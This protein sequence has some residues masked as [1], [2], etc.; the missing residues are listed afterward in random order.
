[1]HRMHFP[2][3]LFTGEEI[4]SSLDP[5]AWEVL[6]AEARPHATVDPEGRD[7]T[8]HDAVLIARRRA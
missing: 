2:D 3:M 1:M 5:T 8:I 4:A 7:I 6:A